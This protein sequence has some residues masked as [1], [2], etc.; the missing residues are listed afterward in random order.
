MYIIQ[1][2]QTWPLSYSLYTYTPWSTVLEMLTVPQLYCK[3][4]PEFQFL[5]FDK[6]IITIK[7]LLIYSDWSRYK[8]FAFALS[9]FLYGA[10]FIDCK[11]RN[12]FL[13]WMSFATVLCYY[14]L[15]LGLYPS[16]VGSF[17]FKFKK[18]RFEV[19]I[20]LSFQLQKET[21]NLLRPVVRSTG[22]NRV[23]VS[24]FHLKKKEDPSFQTLWFLNLKTKLPTDDG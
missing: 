17:V 11:H 8:K 18:S 6:S 20:F 12:R 3:K 16:S 1:L 14:F 13:L 4:L 24:L 19:W 22:S 2:C 5:L 21:P 10:F 23:G 9:K 7:N 15:Y